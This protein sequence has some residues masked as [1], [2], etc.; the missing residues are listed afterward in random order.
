MSTSITVVVTCAVSASLYDCR[1]PCRLSQRTAPALRQQRTQLNTAT[2]FGQLWTALSTQM[3]RSVTEF[4]PTMVS[5]GVVANGDDTGGITYTS[6]AQSSVPAGDT[7]ACSF[8]GILN[9]GSSFIMSD[10]SK[11]HYR[12]A[13]CRNCVRRFACV[14]IHLGFCLQH[15]PPFT[16][17]ISPLSHPSLSRLHRRIYL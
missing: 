9:S 7:E 2:V 13:F 6:C 8:L 17:L 15:L 3:P 1:T 11:S 4:G 5:P 10:G 14:V 16:A 12:F